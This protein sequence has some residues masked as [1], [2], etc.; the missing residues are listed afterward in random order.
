V[1]PGEHERPF[2]IHVIRLPA[3]AQAPRSSRNPMH[4]S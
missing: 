3:P 2:L 1:A 4:D